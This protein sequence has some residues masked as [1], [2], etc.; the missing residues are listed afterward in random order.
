MKLP[1]TII[2]AYSKEFFGERKYLS[3]SGQFWREDC[4]CQNLNKY[5][6]L[7][8][9]IHPMWWSHDGL[10]RDE[11][12]DSFLGGEYDDYTPSIKLAKEKHEKHANKISKD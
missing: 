6:R 4:L 1:D 10:S 8:V 3:D 9:L 5:E 12:M 2:D 11:I 7:Q